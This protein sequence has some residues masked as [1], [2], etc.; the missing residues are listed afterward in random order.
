MHEYYPG[1]SWTKNSLKLNCY[2]ADNP[3]KKFLKNP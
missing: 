1:S 2:G 3:S